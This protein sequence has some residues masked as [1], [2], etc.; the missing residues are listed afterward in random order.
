MSKQH[1]SGTGTVELTETDGVVVIEQ[2]TPLTR[3]HY[4]DGKALRADAFALEQDYHRTRTRLANVAGGWGAVHGLG[5]SLSGSRLKVT[6]GMAIT[7][8]GN[9]VLATG[10]MGADLADL[11]SVAVPPPPAGSALFADCIERAPSGVTETAGLAIYEITVGPVEGLCGNE[12]VYGKLCETACASDSRHPYWRE[13][14]VIRLRPVSLQLPTS[15]AV[16]AEVIHLR[17]RVAS[18][19]FAAEPWLTASALSASGLASGVWCQPATLYDRNEVVIGLL[20]R[21]G[22]VNRVIDAWSGRRERMDTQA[23]GYWQ[24]RMAMRPWNVFVAQILQFQCQLSELFEPGTT[25]IQPADDCDRLRTLLG[26]TRQELDGLI[27]RY[28]KSTKQ[29]LFKAE[30]KPTTKEMQ[31]VASEMAS[32]FANLDDLSMKLADVESGKGALP[33]QRMLLAAGFFDLPPAGYLPVD[34]QSAVEE[35]VQRMFGEGVRLHYHAVRHDE[36]AHLVEEAQHMA[37][38]SLTRGL[39]DARQIEPVEIF[40]PDGRVQDA[41]ALSPGTWWRLNM[42][43]SAVEALGGVINQQA[44]VAPSAAPAGEST[45]KAGAASASKGRVK[46]GAKAAAASTASSAASGGGQVSTEVPRGRLA[47]ELDGLVRTEKR[48]NG[49]RGITLVAATDLP[50]NAVPIDTQFPRNYLADTNLTFQ[51]FIRQVAFYVAADIDADPFSL[52]VGGSAS[53]TAE[54]R[55]M[56]GGRGSDIELAGTVTVLTKRLLESGGEERL[57]QLSLHI[58]E[59]QAG[60]SGSSGLFRVRLMLRRD[61]DARTGVFLVDDERGDPASSPVFVEWDDAPRRAEIFLEVDASQAFNQR[62]AKAVRQA[63]GRAAAGEAQSVGNAIG[64]NAD[65][66]IR[67]TLAAAATRTRLLSVTALPSMPEPTSTIGAAAMNVLVALAEATDDPAFLLRARQRLFPTID[68]PKVQ[69]V[70]ATHDWLMFRRARTHLCGPACETPAALAIETFQVWHLRVDSEDQLKALTAALASGDERTLALFAFRRVGVLR[71][72]D[73][74]AFSEESADRVLAMWQNANPGPQVRLGR[75]W[76]SA[77]TT[78]QGWQNHFRLRNMLEQIATLT[79]PP[80]AG[81]GALSAVPLPSSRLADGALDGGMLVVTGNEVATV[82]HRLVML[83]PGVYAD[84]QPR[85]SA[86]PVQGWTMFLE[87][88]ARRPDAVIDLGLTFTGGQIDEQGQKQVRE[89]DAQMHQRLTGAGVALRVFRIDAQA[90]DAAADAARQHETIIGLLR[91]SKPANVQDDQM[92]TVPIADLGNGAQVL[93]LVG[94][95][96]FTD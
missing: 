2:A 51:V 61:G 52:K 85:L 68:A 43:L 93:T 29:I 16:T 17:N 10:D 42:D 3:L 59:T 33:K 4:F 23:R 27:S 34:P 64:V 60:S 88:L 71:Y 66:T 40:V 1:D 14:V 25:V 62:M 95:D 89:G 35:Q 80:P 58:S 8:A 67:Q 41:A 56:V 32:S 87:V 91:E 54:L 13:G 73:E 77:P 83:A 21:E 55:V 26:R 49:S 9:F 63:M 45:A 5:V 12:P 6:A 74:S 11:L 38:I 19:Y 78:G 65:T 75:V 72:R 94:Y 18:A 7:A 53:I 24:G 48:A 76:E 82:K 79:T 37:R 57:V 44:A 90:V 47:V 86:D 70:R 84:V 92:V 28:G 69:A 22:G 96:R 20:A 39:D 30:G 31:A 15:A 46:G 50:G 81:S 36:I